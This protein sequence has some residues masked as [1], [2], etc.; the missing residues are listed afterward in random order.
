MT[1]ATNKDP[2]TQ[3]ALYESIVNFSD[4]AIFTKT[5]ESIVTSWN[6]G[7]ETIFGYTAAEIV[8]KNI[9]LIIPP[10]RI[11]EEIEIIGRVKKGESVRHYETERVGK[12]GRI[13]NISLT[14]SPLKDNNGIITGVSGIARESE[15]KYY[16]L[17]QN[18]PVPSWVID[19]DTFQFLDVN[20][21]AINH[22]GYSYEEFL[23]MTA[24]DIR[25]HEEQERFLKLDRSKDHMGMRGQWMHKKRTGLSSR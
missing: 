16:N 6:K 23:S 13:I 2:E 18:Y 24:L 22:Y 25:P 19:Q 10:I 4:D 20:K 3:Q 17:F 9:S 12:G 1:Q 11:N 21:A 15:R 14:V 8:G 5:L 7:A